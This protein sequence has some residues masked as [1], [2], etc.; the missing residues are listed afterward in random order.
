MAVK[1]VLWVWVPPLE[2]LEEYWQAVQPAVEALHLSC[3]G[4]QVGRG[5]QVVHLDAGDTVGCSFCLRCC[6]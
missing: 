5:V 1:S 4:F 6:S 2:Q 3:M